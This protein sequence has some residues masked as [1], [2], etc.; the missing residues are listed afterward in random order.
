MLRQLVCSFVLEAAPKIRS[1]TP[2]LTLAHCF[3]TFRFSVL[4]FMYLMLLLLLHW[5]L[6]ASHLIFSVWGQGAQNALLGAHY[7]QTSV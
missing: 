4:G 6:F 5:F 1:R 2:R 7:S 3:L